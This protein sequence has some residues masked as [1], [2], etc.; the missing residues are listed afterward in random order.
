M[1][2]TS[3]LMLMT[4]IAGFFLFN[5]MNLV[6]DKTT[7]SM[8]TPRLYPEVKSYLD[9]AIA[10]S[11][12]I[13]AERKKT[14][15]AMADYISNKTQVSLTFI[16]TH[17]SRRSHMGQIWASAA[18]AYYGLHHEVRTFSGG[19]EATAFNPRAVEAL[20]RAGMQINVIEESANPVYEVVYA[21]FEAPLHCFSKIYTHDSN[22][23]TGFAAVMTCS[24]A[25]EACP[26]VAG[27]DARFSLPY[28]DPKKYDGT[29]KEAAKYDERSLQIA[30]EMMYIMK[31]ASGK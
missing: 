15:D 25:D 17:N 21:D 7:R 6:T 20:K 8:H 27:S 22:P 12:K 16:C 9:Q 23:K 28:E 3:F 2:K 30:S 19:T 31:K 29:A 26:L 14:L 11:A 10:E 13:S 24:E 1:K 4:A 5:S 18:A